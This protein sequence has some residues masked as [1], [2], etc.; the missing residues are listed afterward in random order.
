VALPQRDVRYRP[1]LLIVFSL[2]TRRYVLDLTLGNSFVE[3]LLAAGFDVYLLDWGTPDERDAANRL[4]D[5]VDDAIPAAIKHVC[6]RSGAAEVN[7]LGYCFGGVLALHAAHHPFSPLRSLTVSAT[8][9]TSPNSARSARRS[10]RPTWTSS[11][12][13]VTTATSRPR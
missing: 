2:V 7:L 4:E 12:C 10:R 6:R 11:R 5:Y 8:P 9:V 13:S 1:P 3:R